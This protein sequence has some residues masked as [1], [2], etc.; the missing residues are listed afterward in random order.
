MAPNASINK[1]TNLWVS[2]VIPLILIGLVG[3]VSWVEIK[4]L[5]VD[6]LLRPST[7]LHTPRPGPAIGILVIYSVLL[8]LFVFTYARLLFTVTVTPG[9]VPR[10]SQWRAL[11][12]SK[13]KAKGRRNQRHRKRSSQ[14]SNGST[15]ENAGGESAEN[16]RISGH[17]YGG[18]ASTAPTTTEAA[19]GLQDFYSRDA[20][21]CQ[22]DGRPNWCS[23]CLN[24][25]PDRAHHCREIERCVRKMDH[26]CPWVGGVVSET[27]FKFFIQFVGW[28]AIYCVF[29]LT[30]AAYFLAEYRRETHSLHVH[31]LVVVCLGALFGLFNLGMTGSSLQ[32]ALINTTTIENLSRRTLVWTLAIHMPKPPETSIGFRTVSF[33]TAT[34]TTESDAP[35]EEQASGAIKTFAILHTKPGEN[36]FDLGPYQNF[37]TVMGDHWYD[38]LLPIRFSPC[39]NHDRRDGQFAMGPVVQRM[40]A[41]AG[42][43][44]VEEISDE[45]MHRKPK[46]S[47]RQSHRARAAVAAP[48]TDS[49]Q[50]E[51]KGRDTGHNRDE[52]DDIDLE[53]GLGHTNGHVH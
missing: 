14:S 30:V 3:Y 44:S 19:P 21:V 34:L 7:T 51:K 39:C 40:R 37:K 23:T 12:E 28:T 33:S 20:F 15:G 13:T 45:K 17:N 49:N 25:K 22:T 29:N 16:G 36:P 52:A 10:C 6:Y 24:W 18:G 50:D 31:W 46:R 43:A 4:L 47:R 2:R 48:E 38:W 27:S 9:Y 35:A 41:E 8:L 53:A 11:R 26:F 5:C 42:I 32:F 1:A